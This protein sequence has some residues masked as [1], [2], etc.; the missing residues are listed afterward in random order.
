MREPA[1]TAAP[2]LVAFGPHQGLPEA[3][4]ALVA[5]AATGAY[6]R[7]RREGMEQGAAATAAQ[8]TALAGPVADAIER[9]IEQ[10]LFLRDA[11]HGE[12]LELAAAIAR[13]VTGGEPSAGGQQ[14]LQ[15][16]AAA[17]DALDDAPLA[18][19][20]NPRDVQVLAAGLTGRPGI[21]VVE[22][23]T[24]EPGEALVRGPWAVAELTRD[25]RWSAVA[26]ALGLG[27]RPIRVLGAPLPGGVPPAPKDSAN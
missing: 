26:E 2:R 19:V 17:L 24:L 10:L 27:E 3:V 20:V 23:A 25:A 16:V 5:A 9:G 13:A 22:D 18:V 4:Q 1:F 21:S 6:D 15:D 14:L 7:G 11:E 8:A 12:L